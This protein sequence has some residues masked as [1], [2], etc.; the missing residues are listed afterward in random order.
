[1]D[2]IALIPARYHSTRLPNKL[3]MPLGNKT[4]IRTT[5][6]NVV[7]TGLFKK[8]YVVTDHELIF[9]EIQQHGGNVIY[10]NG[11][12]ECGTDRIAS[13]IDNIEDADVYI[14]VQGD[15]PFTAA[16]PLIQLINAFK[17]DIKQE[18]GVCTLRQ[19]INEENQI[20]NPN[21]VKVITRPDHSAIYFSR[22]PIPF[23][24]DG[25]PNVEYYKHIGIY[26]FRK[27]ALKQ[28]AQLPVSHLEQ[29]EKLENLRFIENNIIVKALPTEYI[30]VGIDTMEDLERARAMINAH[31]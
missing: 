23:N 25:M 21:V 26:A 29:I 1:M 3:L 11:T 10:S 30:N 31:N 24:R 7:G 19:L 13:I 12:F 18:L 17:E 8:V 15:E 2:C 6:D 5:Y 20:N 14:N 28:F 4:V 27:T 9:E 22:L 16:A